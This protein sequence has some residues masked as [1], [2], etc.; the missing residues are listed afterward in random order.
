MYYRKS[1]LLIGLIS[2]FLFL[3]IGCDSHAEKFTGTI[4][5][6]D[7]ANKQILVISHLEIEDLHVDYKDLLKSGKYR[8]VIWV[9]N[10]NP[11]KYKVGE[12]IEVTYHARDDSYPA[13]IS[14]AKI[15]KL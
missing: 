8:E 14:S 9:K 5:N 11:N 12:E 10:V 3:L 6:I 1:I 2:L 4:V 15:T 7:A 13:Q